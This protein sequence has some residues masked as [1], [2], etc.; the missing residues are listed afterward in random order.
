MIERDEE[1]QKLLRQWKAPAASAK[2]DER[3]WSA[4]RQPRGSRGKWLAVAAGVLVAGGASLW[5]AY[6]A[7][8]PR[9][10][11]NVNIETRVDASGFRPVGN[12]TITV[13]K[14][15]EKQ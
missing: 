5:L 1:L 6:P 13:V 11:G 10:R 2:L 3:V 14:A 4:F 15:G 12:G 9:R 7:G 8:T